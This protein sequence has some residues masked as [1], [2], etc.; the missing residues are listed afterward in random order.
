MEPRGAAGNETNGAAR[1]PDLDPDP[2]HD[3]DHDH[4][5]DHVCDIARNRS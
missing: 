1:R 2:D 4:D 5:L 3:H